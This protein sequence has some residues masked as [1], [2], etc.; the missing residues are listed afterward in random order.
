MGVVEC[1]GLS[2]VPEIHVARVPDGHQRGC[3]R[4]HALKHCRLQ[5]ADCRLEIQRAEWAGLSISAIAV[6]TRLSLEA[7]ELCNRQ[8][9]ICNLKSVDPWGSVWTT[10]RILALPAWN[11]SPKGANAS[12]ESFARSS[13]ARTTFS[14]RCWW[15]CSPGDI[16]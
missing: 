4:A 7:L 10:S 14:T 12:S 1:G 16:A 3:L 2:R 8:S 6:C 5:I 11:G 15:R 13:S 9:E